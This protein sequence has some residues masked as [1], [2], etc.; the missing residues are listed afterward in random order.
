MLIHGQDIQ[1]NPLAPFASSHE[2]VEKVK[3]FGRIPPALFIHP[4]KVLQIWPRFCGSMDLMPDLSFSAQ[5]SEMP[6]EL[7]PSIGT[8]PRLEHFHR[9]REGHR[10]AILPILKFRILSCF[11]DLS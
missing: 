8:Q 11:F 2:D 3:Q 10:W 1:L 4:T 7:L 6:Q 9:L 5:E